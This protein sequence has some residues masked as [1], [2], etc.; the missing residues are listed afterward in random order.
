MSAQH[1]SH[2]NSVIDPWHTNF[3]PVLYLYS[4]I[5]SEKELSNYASH[6]MPSVAAQWIE[7]LW[8]FCVIQ[9][10]ACYFVHIKRGSGPSFA[11]KSVAHVYYLVFTGC[12][13]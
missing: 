3:A 8:Q 6:R 13:R 9:M 11:G 4:I 10:F 7:L 5:D 2:G 12:E 1:K